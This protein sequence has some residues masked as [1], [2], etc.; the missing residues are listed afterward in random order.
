MQGD[1]DPGLQPVVTPVARAAPSTTGKAIVV[2]GLGMMVMNVMAY[3]F[4]LLAAHPL[5][6]S[7]FGAVAALLGVIIV[8]RWAR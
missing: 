1:D 3:G 8:A 6:P 2:V 5:G 7:T 4:T